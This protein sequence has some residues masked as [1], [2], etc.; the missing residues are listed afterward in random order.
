MNEPAISLPQRPDT[1]DEDSITT[2][3]TNQ[4]K[5]DEGKYFMKVEKGK[6]AKP[7]PFVDIQLEESAKIMRAYLLM[8]QV[9]GNSKQAK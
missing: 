6:E 5:P 3:P 2:S 4:E 9:S 8:S 1:K 7:K